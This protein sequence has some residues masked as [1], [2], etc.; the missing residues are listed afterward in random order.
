MI[1]R[2]WSNRDISMAPVRQDI[3]FHETLFASADNK[4]WWKPTQAS[5]I[6]FISS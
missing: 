3:K 6:P 2:Q 1:L 5:N 4:N